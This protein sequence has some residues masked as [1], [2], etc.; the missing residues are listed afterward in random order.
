MVALCPLM[1]AFAFHYCLH[2]CIRHLPNDRW[3]SCYRS[4]LRLKVSPSVGACFCRIYAAFRIR[5]FLASASIIAAGHP[6]VCLSAGR[7]VQ[8]SCATP[9]PG[10]EAGMRWWSTRRRKQDWVVARSGKFLEP[11][12]AACESPSKLYTCPRIGGNGS[13]YWSG[14][15]CL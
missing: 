4:H 1:P 14:K 15:F 3:P 8:M 7:A 11:V 6:L 13:G 10:F 12:L 9:K 5:A 2:Q